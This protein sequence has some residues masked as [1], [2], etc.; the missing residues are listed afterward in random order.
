[1]RKM[2]GALLVL[3][4]VAPAVGAEKDIVDTAVAAQFKT[5]DARSCAR[6]LKSRLGSAVAKIKTA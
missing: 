3:F 6:R 5:P 4:S 1:M 2:L